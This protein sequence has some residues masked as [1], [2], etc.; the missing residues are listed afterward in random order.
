MFNK[1]TV[2][3]TG[4]P[5]TDV[6]LGNSVNYLSQLRYDRSKFLLDGLCTMTKI[7]PFLKWA[8]GK[9][10]CVE[11]ILGL[12]PMA[13]KLIEPFTGSGAV[14]INSDFQ[15]YLLAE[16]NKDLVALFRCLQGE[17]EGFIN[18]C[19]QF[20]S[21]ENNCAEQYYKLRQQF[22]QS[23]DQRQRSALFL[24]LN[25]HGYNGLCRYNQSGLYNVPFGLYRK[26]YFPRQEMNYFYQ[27]SKEAQF[28][29]NDFRDTFALAK[30]GDLI[31]CDPPYVPLSSSAKFTSYTDKQF[32]E[33]DQID[34]AQLAKESA[35]QGITV[36]ISNHDT[37]FTR[38][39][40][41][42]SE[43]VS[44][45]VKRHISCQAEMRQQAQEL[46]AIFR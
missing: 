22:N 15:H 13:N 46:I 27:K 39:H 19:A 36:I 34:L 12:F 25:R 5:R 14:F 9:F 24:Y 43:I 38:Y 31:Y 17:G 8:G 26:P 21:G 23:T 42:H 7:R 35:K 3:P 4:V 6:A 37:E 18:Y 16:E 45:P 2:L 29:Q 11:T 33:K 1:N 30:S 32:L 10:R 28:I 41:R 20:F 44:F 40:Y